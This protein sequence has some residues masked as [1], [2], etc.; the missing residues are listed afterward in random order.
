MDRTANNDPDARIVMETEPTPED[1]RIFDDLIYAFNAQV[2]GISDGQLLASFLRDESGTAIGGVYGWTWGGTCHVRYLFVPAALRSRG[3]GTRLMRAVETEASARGCGQIM[4]E[5]HDFQAPA[6]YRRLGFEIVGRVEDYPRGHQYLTMAKRLPA[7]V[8]IR[9]A[10]PGEATLLSALCVRSKAHWGYDA[11]FMA[12]SWRSLQIEPAAIDEARV[13]VAVDE[14]DHPLGVAD[15]AFL[16]EDV[17]LVHLFVEPAAFGRGA[18]R[19]L[20]A[21]ALEWTRA[22][23]RRTLLIAS[24]PNAVGFYRRLGAIDAGTVPSEA[25]PGRELP[26]LTCS[27]DGAARR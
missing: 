6:F 8:R 5:T 26:L 12:R 19:A 14:A 15:C 25:I 3:H 10:R 2:T 22:Q 9:K 13:F 1:V 4:L 17:D 23:G 21:A 27:A 20:F 11:E 7:P 18:G 24:D 16:G